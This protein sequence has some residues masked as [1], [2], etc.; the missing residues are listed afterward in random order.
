MKADYLNP[1]VSIFG[2]VPNYVESSIQT[3]RRSDALKVLMT[4]RSIGRD[5]LDALISKT[6]DNARAAAGAATTPAT[7]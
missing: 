6:L 4:L 2:D 5:G 3:T 1:E 7:R